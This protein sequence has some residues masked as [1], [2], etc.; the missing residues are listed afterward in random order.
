MI[1]PLLSQGKEELF[2]KNFI[3]K[4]RYFY[5]KIIHITHNGIAFQILAPL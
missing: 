3:G 5:L 2:E 1:S 4:S